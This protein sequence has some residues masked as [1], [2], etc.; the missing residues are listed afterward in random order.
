MGRLARL[1]SP[2]QPLS[3]AT[4]DTKGS[5]PL[6]PSARHHWHQALATTGTKRSPPLKQS[7]FFG[8]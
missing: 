6:A 8:P 4:T 2:H 1:A 5:P 7:N 3:L